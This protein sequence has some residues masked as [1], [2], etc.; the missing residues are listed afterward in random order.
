M[1]RT[2]AVIL[3]SGTALLAGGC[4][5]RA[6]RSVAPAPQAPSAA[7]VASP[8]VSAPQAQPPAPR[9]AKPAIIPREDWGSQPDI[10]RLE[11]RRHTPRF[12]T[13]H[14]AGVVWTAG[15]DPYQKLKGLQSWG[16]RDRN[17]P[18]VPYHYLIP[19]DGR[20][21]EGRSTDYP[22]DTNT[23]EFDTVGHINVHLWGSLGEQRATLEMLQATVD[24]IAWLCQEHAIDP[25]TI[26]GHRD[27]ASTNCP[28]ADMYRYVSDGLI[29]K[30]V[31]EKLAGG[32]PAVALLPPLPDG[33]FE[34]VPR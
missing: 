8:V 13:I 27:H 7:H 19:P 9:V 22:P 6:G 4:G 24:V 16:A 25:A 30:W 32:Q 28:G 33:P 11:E 34:F 29:E 23:R 20:I 5:A 10:A 21:F 18:D 3:M 26:R 17:W 31:R 1:R 14:H 12:I 2:L 15:S